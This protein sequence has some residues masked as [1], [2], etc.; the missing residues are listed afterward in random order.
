VKQTPHLKPLLTPAEAVEAPVTLLFIRRTAV[1][2]RELIEY[3]L[4]KLCFGVRWL[5]ESWILFE[6]LIDIVLGEKR[7][8]VNGR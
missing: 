6:I 4:W 7:S 5:R 3:I 2:L 8:G 1:L